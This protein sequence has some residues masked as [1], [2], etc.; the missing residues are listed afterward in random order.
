MRSLERVSIIK[1]APNAPEI[2]ANSQEL[3]ESK[4]AL[5]C[6]ELPCVVVKK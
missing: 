2:H 4:D 6:N 3:K 5:K 1:N